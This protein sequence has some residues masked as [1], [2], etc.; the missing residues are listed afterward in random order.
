ML[1]LCPNYNDAVSANI[2]ALFNRLTS[3]LTQRDLFDKYLF[4][5]V[6]SGYSGSDLVAQQLLGAMCFNKTAML[7]PRFCLMQT[8][9]DPGSAKTM[10][11]IQ[12]RLTQF[13]EN[14]ASVM[15]GK[16]T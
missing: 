1:F 15:Q 4:G 11:G 13:A 8:A 2:M 7:P 3:L 10:P 14:L 6:V 12:G 16:G 9:N 5:I